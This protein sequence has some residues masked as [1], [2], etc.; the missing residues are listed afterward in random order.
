MKKRMNHL[1]LMMMKT[2]IT[3]VIKVMKMILRD[4]DLK[5]EKLEMIRM[6]TMMKS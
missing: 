2:K 6:K 5:V 4:L 1:L 3:V